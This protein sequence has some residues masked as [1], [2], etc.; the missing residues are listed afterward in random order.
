M[1][2]EDQLPLFK[3]NHERAKDAEGRLREFINRS[4]AQHLRAV[5]KGFAQLRKTHEQEQA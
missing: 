1:K 4:T 3:P 2:P 5:R